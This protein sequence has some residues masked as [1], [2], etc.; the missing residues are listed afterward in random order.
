MKKSFFRFFFSF[1]VLILG[2]AMVGA[3]SVAG[4]DVDL[5]NISLINADD[6]ARPYHL[7][8]GRLSG[9]HLEIRVLKSSSFDADGDGRPD[10]VVVTWENYGGSGNFR[11]LNLLL[12]RDGRL[13]NTDRVQLGDRIR[14][15]DLRPEGPGK[16]AVTILDRAPGAAMADSP[17][18]IKTLVYRVEQ[19]RLKKFAAVPK[20]D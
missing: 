5:N 14:V 20:A 2:L 13:V 12:N 3:S 15:E 11:V 1:T 6:P 7:V 16:I 18:R 10:G 17:A 8:D 19:G 4:A 9:D